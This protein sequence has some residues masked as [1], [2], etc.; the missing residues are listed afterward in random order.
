[1]MLPKFIPSVALAVA[2]AIAGCQLPQWGGSL[3]ERRPLGAEFDVYKPS[4]AETASLFETPTGKSKVDM[5]EPTG[6]LSLR[7]ALSLALA[8]SPELASFAWGV[9]EAE[10]WQLQA[11]VPPNPELETEFE[12][13]GGSGDF[14]GTRSL[15][16]T[17]ALSQLIELGG[18]R[19]KRIKLA[20]A[21]SRLA[22][23]RYEAKRLSV[24]TDT[25]QRFIA[26]LAIQKK[27][28]LADEDLKLASAGFDAVTKQVTAGKAS[29]VAKTKASVEVATGKIRAARI[30][31]ALTIARHEL[32]SAWGATRP[33]FTRLLG[34]LREIS[35]IPPSKKLV[36]HLDQNP[37][38]AIWAA[39]LQQRQ[40]ALDLARAGAIPD[41]T[42]GVGYRHTRE[43]DDND[44]AI[45]AGVS[46]PLPLFDRNQGAI[47]K[48]GYS[49]LG[50]KTQRRGA[51][52]K[53]HTEFEKAYQTL[54]S[55]HAEAV[56]LRDEVLPA[57]RSSHEASGKSFAQGKA[58]YMDVLDA[59]RTLVEVREQYI[60]ALEAY[61]SAVTRV[62]GIIAQPL[63][64][65]TKMTQ[66]NKDTD[67]DK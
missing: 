43:T 39:E 19:A 31:R 26:V 17:V 57:A 38:L 56:T 54:A 55:A 65:I 35:A 64:S 33:Q 21:D 66:K 62:E 9:R 37:E 58:G 23:W 12:N 13:F 5:G 61:H 25:T 59:Q 40:A 3:P 49:L 52:V 29:L 20:Q 6:E 36:A 41:V 24:L 50:A 53:L 28:E 44:H 42:A 51:E 27:L 7:R 1:M 10:A 22:G 34:D 63:K 30:R 16:T 8:K 47:R 45:V 4:G 67:N 48:A 14:R 15:E 2:L 46:I 60:E 32:A 11:A 18:K